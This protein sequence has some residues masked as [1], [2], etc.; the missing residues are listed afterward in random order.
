MGPDQMRGSQSLCFSNDL[1]LKILN[2][3][4]QKY[5]FETNFGQCE[6][7]HLLAHIEIP[8]ISSMTDFFGRQSTKFRSSININNRFGKHKLFKNIAKVA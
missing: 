4:H 1:Q 8:F 3:A 6:K 7:E 5:K 2:V